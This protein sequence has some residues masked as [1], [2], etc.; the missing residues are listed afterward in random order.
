MAE[1]LIFVYI[2]NPSKQTAE[3]IALRLLEKKLIA[4][5]NI[6]A[7]QSIYRWRGRVRREREHVLIAKTAERNFAKVQQEVLSAHPYEIPCIVKLPAVANRA[8]A[9]WVRKEL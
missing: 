9:Q 8:F 3:R 5:A 1:K 7:S 6:Y 4:C 2:T